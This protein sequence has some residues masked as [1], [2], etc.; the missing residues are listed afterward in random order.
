MKNN[1]VLRNQTIYQV[2]VRNYSEEGTFKALEHDLPRI[3]DL[4][5]SILYLLPIHPI[6]EVA[7]KGI[8][9]S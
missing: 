2:Y 7:R 5:V 1:S 8:M 6:G 9:G 4:G 3:K